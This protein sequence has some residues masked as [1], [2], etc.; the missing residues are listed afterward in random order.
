MHELSSILYSFFQHNLSTSSVQNP[1]QPAAENAKVKSEIAFVFIVYV[2]PESRE[3]MNF[4]TM[5][6]DKC[7]NGWKNSVGVKATF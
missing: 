6:Q 2:I 1:L 5:L 3:D 4:K 7:Q